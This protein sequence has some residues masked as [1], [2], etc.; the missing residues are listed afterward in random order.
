MKKFF[1]VI[2]V[3]TLIFSI[4]SCY[5]KKIE[6]LE[7]GGYDDIVYANHNPNIEFGLEFYTDENAM[8]TIS[9]TLY[10]KIYEARYK[11]STKGYLY[12]FDVDTYVSVHKDLIVTISVNRNTGNIDSLHISHYPYVPKQSE[13]ISEEKCKEA[14]IE[15]CKQ[16][17]DIE[18]YTL[19][20]T[21]QKDNDG[22]IE[23]IFSFS[24][25]IDDYK[26]SDQIKIVVN[27]FGE[28]FDH[29]FYSLGEMKDAK[30]PK[31][32]NVENIEK[33]I[34][35]K[36]DSMY[37]NVIDEYEISYRIND[38]VFLKTYD[39]QYALQYTIKVD[40]QS[41]SDDYINAS[42]TINFLVYV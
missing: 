20:D 40:L 35:E 25:Y 31:K 28:I 42:E 1:L 38:T 37:S 27:Q 15:Y 9:T 41:K 36:I 33:N 8:K 13:K 3:C 7:I 22:Y 39:G 24:R 17:T 26:T 18:N 12:N 11:D 6:I 16:Y 2:L 4:T 19:V 29:D 21:A 32:L 34:D 5:N 30:V 14:A 10:G 23:Y